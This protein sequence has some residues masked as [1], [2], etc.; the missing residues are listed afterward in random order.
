[1]AAWENKG[2]KH[3]KK[4]IA[5]RFW[6]Y[7]GRCLGAEPSYKA[8]LRW[9]EAAMQ[10]T[11]TGD[12]TPIFL[13]GKLQTAH[14]GYELLHE[15]LD[16]VLSESVKR[17]LAHDASVVVVGDHGRR[18]GEG[19]LTDRPA[20][21]VRVAPSIVAQHEGL[22][23]RLQ[24]NAKYPTNHFDLHEALQARRRNKCCTPAI[25]FSTQLSL[26]KY[27]QA[28]S[29]PKVPKTSCLHGDSLSESETF[30]PY[31][32]DLLRD[33]LHARVLGEAR[34]SGHRYGLHGRSFLRTTFPRNTRNCADM[35][36][37]DLFCGCEQEVEADLLAPPRAR[38]VSVQEAAR[39]VAVAGAM[40]QAR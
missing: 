30:W 2:L 13:S 34:V 26:P 40:G 38:G 3:G 37:R 32:Q 27:S 11:A 12:G 8:L 29:S 10:R 17:L 6:G 21:W 28:K 1:M 9:V 31:R 39:R 16:P 35:G 22:K 5:P 7:G 14:N 24:E 36:I 4:R 25:T 20:L 33:A 23:E 19:D 18:M 15:W